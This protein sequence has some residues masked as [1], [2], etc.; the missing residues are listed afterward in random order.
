[1]NFYTTF[2]A[3]FWRKSGKIPGFLW[4]V[5]AFLL[6]PLSRFFRRYFFKRGFLDCWPG[7]I[8]ALGDAF[9]AAVSYAKF[10]EMSSPWKKF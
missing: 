6:K 9:Q 10:L 2:Q 8:A 3:E 5:Q 1:M 7:Y 4:G